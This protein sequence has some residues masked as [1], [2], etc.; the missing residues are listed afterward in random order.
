[1]NKALHRYLVSHPEIALSKDSETTLKRYAFHKAD[2]AYS[3]KTLLTPEKAS[4]IFKYFHEAISNLRGELLTEGEFVK[5][6]KPKVPENAEAS[7]AVSATV[8]EKYIEP[9]EKAMSSNF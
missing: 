7:S 3:K 5:P 6:P 9:K 8:M 4:K 2:Q 1:M